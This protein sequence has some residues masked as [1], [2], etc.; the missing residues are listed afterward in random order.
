MHE[1]AIRDFS[2]SL[3]FRP[4]LASLWVSRGK[5][6]LEA[7]R[8][9]GLK[10]DAART[11]AEG[12]FRHALELDPA[13]AD[14]FVG[15]GELTLLAGDP[16]KA[17]PH[18]AKAVELAPA[19]APVVLA[20]ALAKFRTK[21]NEGAVADA[22]QALRLGSQ[23]PAAKTVRARARCNAGDVGAAQS[24]IEEVLSKHPRYAPAF[25]ALGDVFRERG[26]PERAVLE[27]GKAIGLDARMAEAYHQRGNA[28]RDQGRLENAMKDLSKALLLDPTDPFLYFDRGVCC[29]NQGAWGQ[30]QAEFRQ[31]IALK[32]ARAD[33]FW[34][35]LWLARTKSGEAEQAIE[36]L[37]TYVQGRPD[38]SAG[39]LAP[40]INDLLLGRLS[41][42]EFVVLL[43]RTEFSRKAIAEGYFFAAEKALAEGRK[44]R[45]EELLKRCLRTGSLTS[46]GYSTAEV[47][48]RSISGSK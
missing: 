28:E 46:S 32:P 22:E 24:D 30:A 43:E 36:E 17:M 14:A 11:Q 48:L 13:H 3:K 9:Q 47:E 35:R 41:D 44:A 12:D 21:D 4:R 42:A 23:D 27:Y 16:A 29:S 25:V 15:L 8:E 2:E 18:F 10:A 39:K 38:G 37:R 5:A 45:G 31:G 26:N 33:W 34:Q 7:V 6:W 20:R 19:S 1:K 40:K